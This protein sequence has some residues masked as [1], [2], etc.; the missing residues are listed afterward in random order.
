MLTK[1]QLTRA[2]EL[3][4][5]RSRVT[6]EAFMSAEETAAMS[7]A[8]LSESRAIYFTALCRELNIN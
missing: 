5:V 6:P 4:E 8:S 1:E 7:V 2:F 3:W